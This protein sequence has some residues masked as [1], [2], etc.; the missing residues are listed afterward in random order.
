MRFPADLGRDFKLGL[1]QLAHSPGFTAVAVLSLALGIGANTAVFSLVN[2]VL[3]RSLPGPGSRTP[4]PPAQRSEAAAAGCRGR[5]RT[6]APSTPRRDARRARRSRCSPS[7]AS[8][9]IIPASP[10]SSPSRRSIRSTCSWTACPRR[11]SWASSSPAAITRAWASR[12]SSAGRSTEDDDRLSAPPVA[13]ISWR[14]WQRRFGGDPAV[15]GK[16][17]QCNRV[18]TVIVGVTPRGFAGA[19]Q[20]GESADITVPLALHARFQPDR[21]ENRAQ[22]CYW[23]IR[24]MGRLAPAATPAQVARRA[25]ADP[26]GDGSRGLARR[27]S[28]LAAPPTRADARAAD[29]RRRPRRRRA[30]TTAA[31]R[32]RESL[33]ILM[34]LVG[35]VLLA[36]CANVAN[37]LLARGAARRP[38]IAVRLALGASRRASCVSCSA[39]A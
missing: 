27:R 28:R 7:R 30:K 35:L 16:T 34:G 12:R 19:M 5:A 4:G 13:V 25:R 17:V 20:V 9:R 22:P 33:R 29:P 1:R 14:Y 2:D 32:Y 31:V 24:V 10:T 3:L 26:A 6:T 21:A 39:S 38:E 15:I 11:R 8:A 18:P 23:W 37:L 36:A